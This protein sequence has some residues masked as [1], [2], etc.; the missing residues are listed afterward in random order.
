MQICS[1]LLNKT[2]YGGS[3]FFNDPNVL[4]TTGLSQPLKHHTK[5]VYVTLGVIAAVRE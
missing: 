1:N 2:A 3:A 5:W 4:W